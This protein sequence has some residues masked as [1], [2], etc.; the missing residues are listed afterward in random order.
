MLLISYHFY[1]SNEIGGRRTTAL[2]RFLASK[3]VRV[4]VVSAFG[5]MTI[6]PGSELMTG[7]IAVPV[8]QPR[9]VL[10][11]FV[12][13]RKQRTAPVRAATAL[14]G[15]VH[16]VLPTSVLRR[17]RSAI[18]RIFFQVVYFIDQYKHWGWRAAR[19]TTRVGRKFDAR[20]VISSSP[21]FTSLLVGR[22]VAWRLGIPHIAD[23]RDP[24]TD[25]LAVARPEQHVELRLLRFLEGWA[26]G[27]AA[28]ITSTASAV[29]EL[30]AA[31]YPATRGKLHVVRNGYEGEVQTANPD[32]GGR[33]AILFAGE[34]YHKRD[35]FPFLAALEALLARPDVDPTRISA[36]FMG[37][38]AQYDGKLLASW[39]EAKRCAKVVKILPESP[40]HEVTK[41]VAESTLLLNLHQEQPLSIPAKT[42][43]HL[44]Y[45]R[46]I[47]L[48]CDNDSET[49]SLVAGI[50]GVNQVEQR[51]VVALEKVLLD[52]YNRHV[53]QRRMTV[54]TKNDI[55]QFSRAAAN[56][57]F[58]NI[59]SS[60]GNLRDRS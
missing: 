24:W 14:E 1:P 10:I 48:L 37:K 31:R 59:I 27:S 43:E 15:T 16:Q 13:S 29:A 41:A 55:V 51:D 28:A 8:K 18:R 9:K 12:V 11:D 49:A 6:A 19:E 35:P 42:F 58:W 47:L 25:A 2:A 17:M 30:L 38:V 20:L 56:E 36:T 50:P 22:W 3:G 60:V 45:A 4:M 34:L 33:L 46:E 54:P 26:L 52:I 40:Q 7:V 53:V 44:A 5:G 39:I 32:T 21:P 23:L 57:R